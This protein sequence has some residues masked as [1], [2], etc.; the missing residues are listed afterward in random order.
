MNDMTDTQD[1]FLIRRSQVCELLLV[2]HGDAIP[3]ADEII[4]SGVYD[5]LPLSKKGREQAQALSERLKQTSIDAAYCSPLRRCRE[6]AAPLLEKKG[7]HPT[8]VEGIKEVKVGGSVDH[9]IP[10]GD[11]PE[12]LKRLTQAL[13]ER[14]NEIIRLAGATGSWDSIEG[15]EPSKGFRK[16]VVTAID[17]IVSQHR[18]ERVI[19]FAHAGV[20]NAYVAEVL[21]QPKE[22]FF[23]CANTSIT[24]VRAWQEQ[25]VLFVLNDVGHLRLGI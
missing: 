6:T 10:S 9:A 17:Q 8:I 19:I 20:I 2:R 22:F 14:H 15:S 5:D 11:D 4:P 25:R 13:R 1:P 23:P 12:T 24:I 18:G 16:R 3:D 7:L 21:D